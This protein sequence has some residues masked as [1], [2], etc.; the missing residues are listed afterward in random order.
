MGSPKLRQ[1]W[2]VGQVCRDKAWTHKERGGEGGGW[3]MSKFHK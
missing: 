2:Q 3:K 1:W